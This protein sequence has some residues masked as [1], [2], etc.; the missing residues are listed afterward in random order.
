MT[1]KRLNVSSNRLELPLAKVMNPKNDLFGTML[2]VDS[3]KSIY[4]SITE[5]WIPNGHLK[6]LHFKQCL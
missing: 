4:F 3:F 5:E 1:N 2:D 6:Y